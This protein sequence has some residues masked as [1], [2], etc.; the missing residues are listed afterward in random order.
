[1]LA[2]EQ[3]IGFCTAYQQQFRLTQ[4]VWAFEKVLYIG[5]SI[6]FCSK[7]TQHRSPAQQQAV[8]VSTNIV[9][10]LIQPKL[11]QEGDTVA[12]ISLSWGGAG[13]LAHRYEWGKKQLQDIFGL[14][15]EE[16]KTL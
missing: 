7:L 5:L 10:A 14:K 8:A 15:V 12:T 16:T 9:A 1:M 3:T 6:G 4:Q 2:N 13:E 11:L